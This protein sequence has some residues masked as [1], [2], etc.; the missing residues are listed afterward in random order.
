MAYKVLITEDFERMSQ[1]ASGILVPAMR[2]A[3]VEQQ[4][5]FNLGLATGNSPTRLYQLMAENQKEFNGGK[6]RSWN[7]DEYIGLPG[8]TASERVV[9]P[10]SY[11]YFMIQHLFGKLSPGF[12]STYLPAGTEIDQGR[13]EDALQEANQFVTFEGT[14][15]GKAVIISPNCKDPYLSW[16]RDQLVAGYAASIESA[17]GIDWWV[18]GSGG[19]G[20]IGFH[21]SGIPLKYLMLLVKLDDNTVDNAVRDGHFATKEVSPWYALSMGAQGVAA[22]ARN[23]LLLA[24]GDR[25]TEPIARSLFGPI[26]SDVPISILQQYIS[27]KDRQVVYVLDQKAAAEVIGKEKKLAEK[28]IELIDLRK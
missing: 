1:A 3:T 24:N 22:Y 12:G 10:E 26:T 4:L 6:V 15:K 23:V 11:A 8:K 21:E 25:K 13:L 9:H 18:V 16:I 5:A 17:G 14:D 7:L 20:H 2:A 27:E 19:K 28:G